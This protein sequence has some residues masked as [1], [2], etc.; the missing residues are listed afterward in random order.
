MKIYFI[1][2]LT[3]LIFSILPIDRYIYICH[4]KMYKKLFS[5]RLTITYGLA[6]WLVGLASDAPNFMSIHFFST[7]HT[8][9]KT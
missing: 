6:T 2:L 4:E 5:K 8:L 9:T 7:Q 1:Y 3:I